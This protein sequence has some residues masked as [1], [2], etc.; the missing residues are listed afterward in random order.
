MDM[1]IFV[2]MAKTMEEGI[3]W[4]NLNEERW[5]EKHNGYEPRESIAMEMLMMEFWTGRQQQYIKS[6]YS[7]LQGGW[8][9]QYLKAMEKKK[10]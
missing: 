6:G 4:T 7:N 2:R 8:E 5:T 1:N 10:L 3:K 9:Q